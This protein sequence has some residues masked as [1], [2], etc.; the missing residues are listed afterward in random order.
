MTN[1]IIFPLFRFR[2]SL[3]ISAKA[4]LVIKIIVALLCDIRP[5]QIFLYI[6]F[7]NVIF[8]LARQKPVFLL[9]RF[10]LV[11]NKYFVHFYFWKTLAV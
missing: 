4:I 8:I 1:V 2:Y 9:L 3:P 5:V 6:Y 11:L 10:F 7:L